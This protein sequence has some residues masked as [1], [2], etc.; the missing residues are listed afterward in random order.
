MIEIDR[1]KTLNFCISKPLFN[2]EDRLN[3]G[4]NKFFQTFHCLDNPYHHSKLIE[5]N[6]LDKIFVTHIKKS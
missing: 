6:D 5:I 1:I 3:L 4:I 2:I